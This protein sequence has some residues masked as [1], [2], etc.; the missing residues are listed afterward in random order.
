MTAEQ[1]QA[2]LDADVVGPRAECPAREL[3]PIV[4]NDHPREASELGDPAEHAGDAHAR[5]RRVDLD[6][7]AF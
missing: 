4:D 6:R 2:L 7:D 3:R 5:Q 1:E